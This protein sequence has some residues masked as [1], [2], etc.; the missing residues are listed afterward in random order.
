MCPAGRAARALPLPIPV[1]WR[2]QTQRSTASN[3]TSSTSDSCSLAVFTRVA[4]A[5][6]QRRIR[7]PL[8][9]RDLCRKRRRK[10]TDNRIR[11]KRKYRDIALRS[12]KTDSRLKARDLFCLG[13]Y[14][15]TKYR[16]RFRQRGTR[17]TLFVGEGHDGEGDGFDQTFV[18]Q[19]FAGLARTGPCRAARARAPLV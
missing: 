4:L 17:P 2:S 19:K 13:C 10:A 9:K 16:P 18:A 6:S 11:G 7:K 8:Q 1:A 14:V 3:H 15:C 5:E 12:F